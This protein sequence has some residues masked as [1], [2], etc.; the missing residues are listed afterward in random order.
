LKTKLSAS[1]PLTS[2]LRKDNLKGLQD[3]PDRQDDFFVRLIYFTGSCALLQLKPALENGDSSHRFKN[4]SLYFSDRYLFGERYATGKYF[5]YHKYKSCGSHLKRR[6]AR[7][8]YI[9]EV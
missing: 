4:R 7:H 9:H 6:H 2:S 5:L 1:L 8:S 3:A